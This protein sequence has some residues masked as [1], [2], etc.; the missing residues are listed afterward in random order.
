MSLEQIRAGL[1]TAGFNLSGTLSPEQFDPLVPEVWQ[2]KHHVPGCRGILVVGSGG[3][4]LWSAFTRSP[5]AGLREDPLDRYTARVVGEVA[6]TILPRAGISLYW[7]KRDKQYLP[8]MKLGER[9]GLGTPGRLGIL[10]HPEFGPW[11]AVRALLYLP[12][13]VDPGEPQSFDPCNGCPAPCAAA[14]LGQVVHE[15]GLEPSDCFRTRV[16]KRGCRVGCAARSACVVGP[17]HAYTP[18]QLAHHQR[19]RWRR[20]VLGYALRTLLADPLGR[21]R[22]AS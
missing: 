6:D 21:G 17:E 22:G 10:L 18:T 5:E 16:L 11:L 9:A 3:R 13:P 19:I 12:F 8:M 20:P 4:A 1:E 7:E 15:A 2:S 14:C